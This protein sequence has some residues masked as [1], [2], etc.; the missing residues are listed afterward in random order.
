MRGGIPLRRLLPFLLLL[1]MLP[2]ARADA[3][4]DG[5]FHGYYAD[6]GSVQIELDF[7]VENGRFASTAYET[8]AYSD[9]DYLSATATQTQ[10]A[11]AA[12][13]E[14]LASSLTGGGEEH[15]EALYRPEALAEPVDAVTGATIKS[16][17]LV[18]AIWDGFLRAGE[19]LP[20]LTGFEAAAPLDGA[21]PDGTYRGFSYAQGQEQLAIQFSLTDGVITAL[22]FRRL[23]WNGH[24]CLSDD[25]SAQN[26]AITA[27]LGAANDLV[28][29]P[30]SRAAALCDFSVDTASGATV[31]ARPLAQAIGDALAHRPLS[32]R[33]GYRAAG[34][35]AAC[36]QGRDGG[37][38]AERRDVLH[39]PLCIEGG[40]LCLAAGGRHRRRG[41]GRR[42]D[43]LLDTLLD[44]L[45]DEP[46]EA[47][48]RL[49]A[50][51]LGDSL[52][53][54]LNQALWTALSE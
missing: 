12:Q 30:V 4:P 18:H 37:G 8:L 25:A 5:H 2:A 44:T 6:G 7:T 39:C 53:L 1:L 50:L 17:K 41:R 15:I 40:A 20:V 47:L 3:L 51:Y 35:C 48:V 45:L 28:G 14:Q 32:R 46:P 42:M 27:F 11:I 54:A 49:Y 19:E 34:G 23:N 10:R 16:G 43:A 21:Y 26:P 52:M 9:G 22:S 36:G 13:F 24:N 31:S 33:A 38:A 29:K